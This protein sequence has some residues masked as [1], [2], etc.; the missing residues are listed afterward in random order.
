MLVRNNWN[1]GCFDSF[2]AAFLL[3]SCRVSAPIGRR[4]TA[5]SKFYDVFRREEDRRR[6]EEAKKIG[7]RGQGGGVKVTKD[8]RRTKTEVAGDRAI[9]HEKRQRLR[10]IRLDE[11]FW[12]YRNV[13]IRLAPR[14]NRVSFFYLSCAT[15][16]T[17]IAFTSFSLSISFLFF[18]LFTPPTVC[19]FYSQPTFISDRIWISLK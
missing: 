9:G 10:Y 5:P 2:L 12:L 4:G 19:R 17:T 1:V 14:F 18:S 8:G 3:I 16:T 6:V 13:L 11:T 15:Y 7:E